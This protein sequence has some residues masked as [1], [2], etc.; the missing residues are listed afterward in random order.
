MKRPISKFLILVGFL[1]SESLNLTAQVLDSEN[2]VGITLSDGTQVI[3]YGRANTASSSSYAKFSNE[4]YYLPTNLRLSEKEDGTPEFIFVKYTTE[5]N[6]AAGGVQGALMH[7]L[8]EWGLNPDQEKELQQ[9]ISAKLGDLKSVN[10]RYAEVKNPKVLGPVTLKSDVE[11][12]TFRIV[13][14]TLTNEKFTPNMVTSGKAPLLPGSKMAVA[15]ILE[16]NGAQLLAATFEKAR[17]ITDVS[18]NLR[19]Q[20]EVLTPAVDGVITVNW[21]Q[22]SQLYQEFSRE[23]SHTDKDDD[24]LP[25]SNSMSDDEITDT[26]KDSLFSFLIENKAVV[27]KLDQLKPDNPIAKEVTDAF[28]EYFLSS[29]AEKDFALPEEG[30]PVESLNNEYQPSEGLY[31][32][33]FNSKRMET[34]M[35][36][37]TENYN[38]KL[39][40]PVVQEMSITENLAS[41]YD[42][43]KH[44]KQCVTSVNLNDPFFQ[45]REIHLILDGEAEQMFGDEVNAVSV[46]IRKRRSSGN[47]F[48]DAITIDKKTLANGTLASLTYARGEDKNPDVYEFRTSWNLKGNLYPEDPKWEKGDWKG[49]NLVAPV[50]PRTILF[51]GDLTE[52]QEMG[53]PRATLQLRYQKFGKEVET[54]IPLTVSKGQPLIEKVI[55][56]DKDTRGYVYRLILTHKTEG[57]L[58]LPWEAKINDDYV[59][60]TIPSDLNDKESDIFKTA[61]EMGKAILAPKD[62]EVNKV[63]AILDGFGEIFSTI[64]D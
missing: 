15:A 7:F 9:Q 30:K 52:L 40:I 53:I 54:N 37:G 57:K 29:V 17:S 34:K 51:E 12:E 45:H 25:V 2:K 43:V 5:E 19:F 10:P 62:G 59:Y 27:I 42:G 32:Y 23:Y 49:I 28:L 26:E 35:R 4:Y 55:Y 64:K 50:A 56:T 44:N 24:T 13:S 63:D 20:Y 47:D 48:Q 31:K 14:G 6:E 39:R 21:T 33:T 3:A 36:M 46:D 16:K 41:W 1:L 61:V 58:V 60:A 22:I 11:G 38:L 18:L 8:M